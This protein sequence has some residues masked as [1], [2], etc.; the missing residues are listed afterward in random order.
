[1]KS[2]PNDLKEVVEVHNSLKELFDKKDYY[3]KLDWLEESEQLGRLHEYRDRLFSI[4]KK[5]QLIENPDVSFQSVK[6]TIINLIKKVL[7]WTEQSLVLL[8]GS[9]EIPLEDEYREMCKEYAVEYASLFYKLPVSDDYSWFMN[10]WVWVVN[11]VAKKHLKVNSEN[12]HTKFLLGN[13]YKISSDDLEYLIWNY[14]MKDVRANLCENSPWFTFDKKEKE[15]LKKWL[16][17]ELREK[18]PDATWNCKSFLLS[19]KNWNAL[20]ENFFEQERQEIMN[21]ISESKVLEN[22]KN[23][24]NF[25]V[26]ISVFLNSYLESR[27]LNKKFEDY[28][29]MRA[30]KEFQLSQQKK[31]K[32]SQQND[33]KTVVK[34]EPIIESKS[35]SQKRDLPLWMEDDI[36]NMDIID[37]NQ[38]IKFLKNELTNFGWHIKMSH[39]KD[40][41]T[42][43]SEIE[44]LPDVLALLDNY[45][46]FIIEEDEKI[47]KEEE[48]SL[49]WNSEEVDVAKNHTTEEMLLNKLSKVR[50]KSNMAKRLFG[51][52]SIFEDLWFKFKDKKDFFIQLK[53][54]VAR[55]DKWCLE[56]SIQTAL[57][58]RIYGN[59]SLSKKKAFWYRAICLNHRSW[60]IV[61]TN[62]EITHILPHSEYEKLINR[63]PSQK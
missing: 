1:M 2:L 3:E 8:S 33:K 7:N 30:E 12:N 49:D 25:I 44:S 59:E 5:A 57:K 54:A 51:Y 61:L 36:K 56:N 6:N 17:S 47:E 19:N 41:L 45:P 38:L 23:S 48:S 42:R 14:F 15:L 18:Y 39:L 55:T 62:M 31:I 11:N 10:R 63:K 53:D 9:E 50:D 37:V 13:E 52:I 21:R 35:E 26:I 20:C 43:M 32:V 34:E 28:M 29:V 4:L 24:F 40:R 27:I 22:S 60:R 16:I 46:E 58:F